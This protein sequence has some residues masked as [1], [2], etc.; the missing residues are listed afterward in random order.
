[1]CSRKT[2]PGQSSLVMAE[3]GINHDGSLEKALELVELAADSGADLVK[4]QYL[5]PDRMVHRERLSGVHD[6][7]RRYALDKDQMCKIAD[8]CNGRGTPFVCTVFSEEGALAMKEAGT[9]AF[10]IA[11]C[12]MTYHPLLKSAAKLGLPVILSTGLADTE[13]VRASVRVLKKAGCNQIVLLHCVSAYP[14][15]DESLNLAAI[16]TMIEEFKL[17]VGFSDHSGGTLAPALAVALGAVMIEKH[18][19]YDPAADGPDHVLSLGPG[20][21]TVMVADIRRTEKMRGSGRK[22]PADTEKTERTV[23]RR[24]YYLKKDVAAGD[25][26]KP[27]DLEALKPWCEIGPDKVKKIRGARYAIDLKAGAP[28]TRSAVKLKKG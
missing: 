2:T 20:D 11:S 10:K 19:T 16:R 26:I 24:G 6:I 12:D 17:P 18:F 5:E 15:P 22:I 23:G 9:A 27:S 13:E 3:I 1:M 4:F 8:A 14:A 25:K 21:F 7:Y 28:L